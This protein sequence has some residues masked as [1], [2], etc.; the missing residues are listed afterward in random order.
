[1]MEGRRFG[2]GLAAGILLALAVVTASGGLGS[3]PFGSLAPAE[4]SSTTT[5]AATTIATSPVIT[6]TSTATQTFSATST[7][8]IPSTTSG[9]PGQSLVSNVTYPSS[10]TSSSTTVSSTTSSGASLNFGSSSA[11]QSAGTSAN[12]G[13]PYY[14]TTPSGTTKPTRLAN[15]AQQPIVS[16]AEIVAPVLIAFLLG[17]FLYR[18]VVQERE[19]SNGG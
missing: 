16:N 5:V 10:G 2:I 14:M 7:V 18:V 6:S 15:I 13:S 3:T 1:M 8:S 12:N 11:N 19:R 4:I 9:S 17:A